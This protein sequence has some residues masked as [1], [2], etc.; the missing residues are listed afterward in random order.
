MFVIARAR[1]MVIKHGVEATEI[2]QCASKE[3][4]QKRTCKANGKQSGDG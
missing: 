1:M 2:L 4:K 3:M